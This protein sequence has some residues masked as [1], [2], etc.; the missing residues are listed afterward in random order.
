MPGLVKDGVYHSSLA[1][2]INENEPFHIT[3][4]ADTVKI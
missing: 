3:S 2:P 1:V 4:D